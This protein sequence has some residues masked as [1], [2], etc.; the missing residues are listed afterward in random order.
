MEQ[1]SLLMLR[2]A[3][4]DKMLLLNLSCEHALWS[5]SWSGQP[6]SFQLTCSETLGAI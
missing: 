6:V 2:I 3:T 1:H 4:G 5:V